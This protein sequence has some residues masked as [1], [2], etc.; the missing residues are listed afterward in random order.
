MVGQAE[1][2]ARRVD[3]PHV[4]AAGGTTSLVYDYEDRV[5]STSRPGMATNTFAYNAFG[6]RVSKHDSG[7]STTYLRSGTSVVASGAAWYATHK[8]PS[9]PDVWVTES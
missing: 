6:A 8:T 9:D 4:V 2:G 3:A 7:G 5:T 1:A